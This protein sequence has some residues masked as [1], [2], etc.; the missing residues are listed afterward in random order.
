M[1]IT[2]P[3]KISKRFLQ[4]PHLRYVFPTTDAMEKRENIYRL[5]RRKSDFESATDLR[6]TVA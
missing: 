2:N 1:A 3:D 5:S 6:L 4:R